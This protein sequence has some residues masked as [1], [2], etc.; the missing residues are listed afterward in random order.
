[1]IAQAEKWATRETS[2]L[3]Y[4]PKP[5]TKQTPR[6]FFE[7]D[8][9]VFLGEAAQFET[10][11]KVNVY[12]AEDL[13]LM[14]ARTHCAWLGRL[15]Y[16]GQQL[17]IYGISYNLHEEGLQGQMQVLD[18]KIQEYVHRM[19]EWH[20]SIGAK[21]PANFKQAMKELKEGSILPFKVA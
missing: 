8:L 1:M 7:H 16:T 14:D 12:E 11:S 3:N 4:G 6:D 2:P 19:A 18:Q 17:F 5:E 15:I 10:A 9:A 20:D 13:Q 21:E